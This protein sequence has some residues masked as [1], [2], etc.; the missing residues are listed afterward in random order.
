MVRVFFFCVSFQDQYIFTH[1][2]LLEFI[3]SQLNGDTEVKDTNI[4]KYLMEDLQAE[5]EEGMPLLMKQYL[6]STFLINKKCRET[7]CRNYS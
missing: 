4:S 5:V 7:Q 3:Q 6:V 2:A 1:D